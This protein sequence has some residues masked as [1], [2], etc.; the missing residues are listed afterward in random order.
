MG[1][2]VSLG[3]LLLHGSLGRMGDQCQSSEGLQ[4][5]RVGVGALAAWRG[6]DRRRQMEEDLGHMVLW[7][8]LLE[9]VSFQGLEGT[10]DLQGKEDEAV[11]AG[12]VAW[13]VGDS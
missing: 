7:V 11:A 2:L 8:A 4:M 12:S 13:E 10:S 1:L 6:L 9:E 5:V 3:D